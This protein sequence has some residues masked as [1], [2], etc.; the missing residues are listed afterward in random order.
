MSSGRASV[1]SKVTASVVLKFT[2]SVVLNVPA[3][4][5]LTGTDA[6]IVR[7]Y[8]GLHVG[9]V[10]GVDV[11]LRMSQVADDQAHHGGGVAA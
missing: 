4:V 7:P 6:Q 1:V 5:V 9:S 8:N 11:V 3:S 10:V 2:V